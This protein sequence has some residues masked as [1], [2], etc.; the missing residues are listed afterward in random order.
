MKW[1]G[2]ANGWLQ[3]ICY[4]L[5]VQAPTLIVFVPLLCLFALSSQEN[6]Y[7]DKYNHE[8]DSHK[9]VEVFLWFCELPFP[10]HLKFFFLDSVS[11]DSQLKQSGEPAGGG[12]AQWRNMLKYFPDSVNY[13]SQIW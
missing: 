11:F 9:Y 13:I 5:F 3:V 8:T 7:E 1:Q 4:L 6:Q 12:G 2:S 10:N